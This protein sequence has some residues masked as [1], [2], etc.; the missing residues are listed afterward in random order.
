MFSKPPKEQDQD[1][2]PFITKSFQLNIPSHTD[3]QIEEEKEDDRGRSPQRK[4]VVL[5]RR[6]SPNLSFIQAKDSFVQDREALYR[7]HKDPIHGIREDDELIDDEQMKE[8]EQR[9]GF[10]I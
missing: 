6:Q 7:D 2:S 9:I 5:E 10:L 3:G 4:R 1:E 8:D